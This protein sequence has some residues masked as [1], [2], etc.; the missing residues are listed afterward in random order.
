[1]NLYFVQR[2]LAEGLLSRA[3]MQKITHGKDLTKT[4]A[5]GVLWDEEANE[6]KISSP[7][8]S[9]NCCAMGACVLSR[10]G[11]KFIVSRRQSEISY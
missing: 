7:G 8:L 6:G 2:S 3:S 10:V 1:M 9:P 4:P 11:K 5:L